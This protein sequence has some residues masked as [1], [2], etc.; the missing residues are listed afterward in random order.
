MLGK[1]YG[2]VVEFGYWSMK[3]ELHF[4]LLESLMWWIEFCCSLKSC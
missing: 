3:K 1:I 2:K 4:R